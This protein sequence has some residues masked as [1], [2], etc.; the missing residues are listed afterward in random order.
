MSVDKSG[1]RVRRMFGEI[2]GR[3]DLLNHLLSCNVDKYWRWYTVRKVRPQGSSPILDVCTGTG[4]LAFAWRRKSEADVVAADFCHPMLVVGNRKLSNLSGSLPSEGRAGEGGAFRD[5]SAS[6]RDGLLFVEADA[7][8]L[9][10]PSDTFQIVSVAFGLRNI[11]DTDRGLRELKRVCQPGGHVAV[12][13]FSMPTCYPLKAVYGWYFRNV[14]PK[15]GQL[16]AR[17]KQQAYNYLPQSVGEFPQR[18]Q[19]ADRMRSAGLSG[20]RFYSLTLGIATLYVGI[21]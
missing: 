20:V 19:L 12:L 10:F 6:N 8:E 13:E 5:M 9:P 14:L 15:V 4:D 11:S 3:Y 17:N 18:E 21:K 16:L 2:A 7:Q 1:E